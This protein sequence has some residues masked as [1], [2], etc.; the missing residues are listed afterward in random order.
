M[1]VS[2]FH[3]VFVTENCDTVVDVDDNKETEIDET[4]YF[5]EWFSLQDE[6]GFTLNNGS[7]IY[8]VNDAQK[9][10]HRRNTE[11]QVKDVNGISVVKVKRDIQ[12]YGINIHDCA[13][14]VKWPAE[15]IECLG[16]LLNL[17]LTGKQIIRFRVD[18]RFDDKA[19]DK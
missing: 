4:N 15:T 16:A 9:L 13:S 5:E 19:I 6:E 7:S 2:D 18:N 3:D 1:Q 12:C 17:K 10:N 8:V 14:V 11:A